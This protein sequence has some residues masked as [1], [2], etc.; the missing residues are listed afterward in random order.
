METQMFHWKR[1]PILKDANNMFLKDED[2]IYKKG[3]DEF[4]L[5]QGALRPI[6]FWEYVF[7]E[8]RFAEV[9][10]MQN[11]QGAFPL[12]PEVNNW[13]WIMRKLLRAKKIPNDLINEIKDKQSWQITQK[14]IPMGGM[15]VYPIGWKPDEKHDFTWNEGKSDAIGYYQ[16]GL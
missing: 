16:E 1:K 3:P 4:T 11:L 8:E 13:A 5:V 7:P 15:A 9:L 2:G 6:E 12:R 14:F 10:A